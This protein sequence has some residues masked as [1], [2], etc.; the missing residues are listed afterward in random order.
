MRFKERNTPNSL[1]D[2]LAPI[3]QQDE[4]R[5]T[6]AR[7][8]RTKL[9]RHVELFDNRLGLVQRIGSASLTANQEIIFH[10]DPESAPYFTVVLDLATKVFTVTHT[11][12]VPVMPVRHSDCKSAPLK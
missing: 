3:M 11:S 8:G 9:E 2:L 12:E 5:W 1:V 7:R 6:V 10:G 4:G